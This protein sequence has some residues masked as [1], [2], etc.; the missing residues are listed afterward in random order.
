MFIHV[1]LYLVVIPSKQLL[2]EKKNALLNK[3]DI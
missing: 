3:S 2:E 1:L